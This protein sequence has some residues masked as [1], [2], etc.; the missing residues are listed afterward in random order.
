LHE[1]RKPQEG[2]MLVADTGDPNQLQQQVVR[3]VDDNGDIVEGVLA[4]V[5]V[6]LNNLTI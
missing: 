3:Y 1:V 5:Q 2:E 6:L 4:V